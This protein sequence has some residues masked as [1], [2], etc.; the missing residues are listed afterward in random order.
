M[1][2]M[3]MSSPSMASRGVGGTYREMEGP[4][5]ASVEGGTTKLLMEIAPDDQ[6]ICRNLITGG[7]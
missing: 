7:E 3:G 5:L 6:R 1:A 4:R 2:E